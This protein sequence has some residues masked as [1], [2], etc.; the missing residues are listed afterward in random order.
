[1]FGLREK[2]TARVLQWETAHAPSL[3][4][5]AHLAGDP[6]SNP[7]RIP[8]AMVEG[9]GHEVAGAPQRPSRSGKKLWSVAKVKLH[10]Y[11]HVTHEFQHRAQEKAAFGLAELV[12]SH[13]TMLTVHHAVVAKV[14]AGKKPW[15]DGVRKLI[16]M[17]KRRVMRSPK[18]AAAPAA[19]HHASSTAL[20][21]H[22]LHAMHWV[23]PL[24]G[25]Y[26][27]A[28]MAH[29]DYHRARREWSTRRALLAT[30]LFY[31]GAACDA[32]DALAHAVIVLCITM[33]SSWLPWESHGHHFEHQLHTASMMAALVACASMCAGEALTAMASGTHDSHHS[34][35]TQKEEKP[36]VKH[37]AATP[38]TNK[39]KVN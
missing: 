17:V 8:V 25:A 4:E 39:A 35:P 2:S 27:I 9:S 19:A 5:T 36:W 38:T 26:L 12:L 21:H 29:H 37:V 1:M 33:P 6:P 18:P 14:S 15:W 30:S 7:R 3:W 23:L 16:R 22:G 34:S 31:L 20:L 24:A 10:A 32:F 11:H 28:H 13:V